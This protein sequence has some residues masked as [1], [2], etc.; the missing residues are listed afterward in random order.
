MPPERAN[1]HFRKAIDVDRA[2]FIT[3]ARYVLA[4]RP[5]EK[6]N[7]HSLIIALVEQTSR[8]SACPGRCS[9]IQPPRGTYVVE[10]SFCAGMQFRYRCDSLDLASDGTSLTSGYTVSF[11]STRLELRGWRSPGVRQ[12]AISSVLDSHFRLEAAAYLPGWFG[13]LASCL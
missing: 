10:R 12:Y 11:L 8:N 5:P 13:W 4:C 6:M 2:V 1:R 3:C 9:R 7:I